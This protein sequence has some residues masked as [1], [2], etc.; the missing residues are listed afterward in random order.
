MLLLPDKNSYSN[1]KV[2]LELEKEIEVLETELL[3]LETNINAFQSQ[4]RSALLTQIQRIQ[5]LTIIYKNQKQ[6][7]K[8][9]RLEQKKRGKNYKEPVGLKTNNASFTAQKFVSVND[10][11]ELKRLYKEAIVQ[12]HP[13]KFVDADDDLN[14]RATAITVQ[15]NEVYKNG[16]LEELNR[17]H[18]HII[19]GNALTYIP[20]QPETINDLQAMM[21]FLRQKKQKL[22]QLL[23]EIKTSAIYELWVSRK[24][25]P[26]M[27]KEL[28]TEFDERIAVLQKRT[29]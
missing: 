28:K 7:K 3:R 11:Q 6:A 21:L 26:E 20:D 9:K 19:S 1:H 14:E 2:I 18:E 13:D 29:K 23:L 12:I 25:I 4:I 5:E 10:Q 24:D 22:Q 15:L 8:L 16:D 27:I 17:L